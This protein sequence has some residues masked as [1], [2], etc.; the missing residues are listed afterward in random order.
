MHLVIEGDI[1]ARCRVSRPRPFEQLE[2][3]FVPTRPGN[4][5]ITLTSR[6]VID[7]SDAQA[8]K[9]QF[10]WVAKSGRLAV[11]EVL[12]V[13][14]RHNKGRTI[15]ED[16]IAGTHEELAFWRPG[17]ALDVETGL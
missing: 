8:T 15:R 17:Q 12:W 4:D 3:A 1:G 13:Q 6:H 2:L 14:E 10:S 11:N 16:R 9:L 7:A 5:P